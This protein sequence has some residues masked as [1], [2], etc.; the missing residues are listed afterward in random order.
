MHQERDGKCK[1]EGA[2]ANRASHPA[3][4]V[5]G[6]DY[7]VHHASMNDGDELDRG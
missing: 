4:R 7:D 2:D 3:R 1:K 6:A 5:G